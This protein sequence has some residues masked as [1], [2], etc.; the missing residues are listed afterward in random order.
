MKANGVKAS[1]ADRAC[2]GYVSYYW[3]KSFARIKQKSK[4]E[5]LEM[6]Y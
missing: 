3:A 6:C 2:Y 4:L 5:N 1:A